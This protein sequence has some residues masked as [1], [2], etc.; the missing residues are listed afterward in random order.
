MKRNY[1]QPAIQVLSITL[2]SS[3]LAGSPARPNLGINDIPAD[4]QW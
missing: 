1:I 2:T 3:L 4:D